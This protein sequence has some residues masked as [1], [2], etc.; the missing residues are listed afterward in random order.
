LHDVNN[1]CKGQ[2]MYD[3]HRQ[4]GRRRSL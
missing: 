4:V 3:V 1:P 2:R